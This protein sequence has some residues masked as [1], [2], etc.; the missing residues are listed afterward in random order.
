MVIRTSGGDLQLLESSTLG[1]FV[2]LAD[3]V[4]RMADLLRVHGQALAD[5]ILSPEERHALSLE[6]AILSV[7]ADQLSRE[8]EG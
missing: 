7:S 8:L 2:S 1:H 4:Q 5:G 3:C 6:A